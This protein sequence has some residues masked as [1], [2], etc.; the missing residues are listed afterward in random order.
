ME[1]LPDINS[2]N[3]GRRRSRIPVRVQISPLNLHLKTIRRLSF[4]PCLHYR[5]HD[6]ERCFSAKHKSEPR[7]KITSEKKMM[8]QP[9]L[10]GIMGLIYAILGLAFG[11]ALSW[12]IG[13]IF[14]NWLGMWFNAMWVEAIWLGLIIIFAAFA[15][16]LMLSMKQGGRKGAMYLSVLLWAF[17]VGIAIIFLIAVFQGVHTLF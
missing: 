16:N 15:Y 13:E 1:Q 12:L 14:L 9:K 7:T 2:G 10:T 6:V 8:N 17:D 5:H 11:L 3:R 4:R